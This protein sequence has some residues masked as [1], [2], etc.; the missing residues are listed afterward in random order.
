MGDYLSERLRELS[1][2]Y[3]LLN[4]RGKGLLIAFDLPEPVGKEIVSECL[5]KGLIINSPQPS[6]IRFM[7]PLIVTKGE[8]D[9]MLDILKKVLKA[10][11]TK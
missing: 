5:E 2:E 8:I 10:H 11:Y 9:E 1:E 6:A 4:I 3:P 7:P